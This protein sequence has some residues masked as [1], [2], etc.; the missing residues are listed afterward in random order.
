MQLNIP[1]YNYTNISEHWVNIA[2]PNK[3]QLLNFHRIEAVK[4]CVHSTMRVNVLDKVK[5]YLCLLLNEAWRNILIS[6]DFQALD[7][8][9]LPSY[10]IEKRSTWKFERVSFIDWNAAK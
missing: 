2:E 4:A 8:F 5:V 10:V 1:F 9:G 3:C 7:I 6:S